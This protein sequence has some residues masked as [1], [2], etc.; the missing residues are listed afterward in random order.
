MR[1]TRA[2]KAA[3][4]LIVFLGLPAFVMGG[5]PSKQPPETVVSEFYQYHFSHD[6]AFTPDGIKERSAWLSPALVKACE[7]YFALPE[8]P[9][10]VPDIDGDPF[11]GSQEYPDTFAVGAATVNKTAAR[12]SMTFSWKDG[13]STKG[14]VILMESDGKW[15]IDN[16]EFPDQD[17]IRQ[18]LTPK[19]GEH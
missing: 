16:V 12:V 7:D 19:K 18:L 17:S 8:D 10:E 9:E 13:H 4:V 3:I 11:T 6:M 1:T 15:R 14:D 2:L 5:A